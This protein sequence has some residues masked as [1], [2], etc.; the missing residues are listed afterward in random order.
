MANI[1]KAAW[2][3][4]PTYTRKPLA[5]KLKCQRG[6]RAW[7]IGRIMSRAFTGRRSQEQK[8]LETLH[9]APLR[10]REMKIAIFGTGGVGGYYGAFCARRA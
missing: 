6:W 3:M 2:P 8:G 10:C 5:L 1:P 4:S 7:C 9:A